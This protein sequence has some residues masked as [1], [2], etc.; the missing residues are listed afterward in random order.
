MASGWR[1]GKFVRIAALERAVG[2]RLVVMDVGERQLF[3]NALAELKRQ[4]SNLNQIAFAANKV[5][6]GLG[7]PSELPTSE[8]LA[9]TGRDVKAI[10]DTLAELLRP[11]VRRMSNAAR[12][13][14]AL[15]VPSGNPGT[16]PAAQPKVK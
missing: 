7:R 11:V 4:G 13:K 12:S 16:K 10:V 2:G 14:A 5:A 1:L 3:A 6:K 9:E 15:Q 8:A